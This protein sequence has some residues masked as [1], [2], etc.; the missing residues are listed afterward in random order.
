MVSAQASRLPKV[1][2]AAEKEGAD[3]VFIDTSPHTETAALAA[4][5]I[6]L[7]RGTLQRYLEVTPEQKRKAVS[8]I[9]F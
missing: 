8:V 2:E 6:E 9:G 7:G 5:V 3:L 1:L 4:I